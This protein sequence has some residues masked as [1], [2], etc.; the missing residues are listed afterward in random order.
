MLKVDLR[1]YRMLS[2]VTL[3]LDD[4]S[5]GINLRDYPHLQPNELIQG[6]NVHIVG[7]HLETIRPLISHAL[8]LAA[9]DVGEAWWSNVLGCTVAHCT[10]DGKLYNMETG[11]ALAGAP[12]VGTT[13]ACWVVDFNGL[14]VLGSELAG[15]YTCTG[16]GVWALATNAI[17]PKMLEVWQDKVWAIADPAFPD[18]LWASNA[19]N[20]AV[21]TPATDWVDILEGGTQGLTCV[22]ATQQQDFQGRPSLIVYKQ[23]L[24]ARINSA[25]ATTGFTYTILGV[26]TGALGRRAACSD[27]GIVAAFDDTGIWVTDGVAVPKLVS[28]KIRPVF[29]VPQFNMPGGLGGSTPDSLISSAAINGKFYFACSF[30]ASATCKLVVVWDQAS[31][32]FTWYRPSW[33]TGGQYADLRSLHKAVLAA[34]PGFSVIR[35]LNGPG[36][37]NNN[38]VEL[39]SP[40]GG[41]GSNLDEIRFQTAF[42]GAVGREGSKVMWRRARLEAKLFASLRVD[43]LADWS[44]LVRSSRVLPSNVTFNIEVGAN[45]VPDLGR[46]KAVS[47]LGSMSGATS[48][49]YPKDPAQ[50]FANGIALTGM[51]PL[52]LQRIDLLA[53]SAGRS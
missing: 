21:W 53:G 9:G 10:T 19:G 29:G 36:G 5:G 49:D 34:L 26:G 24:C 25:N 46:W 14:L 4:F 41:G 3:S 15:I 48:W 22:V 32:G 50:P 16:A 7:K 35:A 31:G 8:P 6:L 40:S 39:D 20:A 37:A 30:D 38:L 11:V 23:R 18:R 28:D 47:I 13:K 1:T 12:N 2:P 33:V 43:V 44:Q 45:D 27:V 52:A 17:K 42:V 51:S